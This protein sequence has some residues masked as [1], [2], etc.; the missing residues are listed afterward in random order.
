M[1]GAVRLLVRED[2]INSHSDINLNIGEGVGPNSTARSPP[3]ISV[4]HSNFINTN[5]LR[6]EHS[7]QGRQ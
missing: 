1:G 6:E 4:V 7:S 5:S 3:T 2:N